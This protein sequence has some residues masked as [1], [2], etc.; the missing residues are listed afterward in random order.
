ML[1]WRFHVGVGPARR[2]PFAALFIA[3]EAVVGMILL[4]VAGSL[5]DGN[6]MS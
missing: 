5:D 6:R 4:T 2:C 1:Q 3:V